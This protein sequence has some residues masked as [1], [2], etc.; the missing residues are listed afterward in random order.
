F[1]IAELFH[2]RLPK[3]DSARKYLERVV[4]DTATAEDSIY[5]RRAL[6]ALAWMETEGFTEKDGRRSVTN[7][8]RGQE[9]YRAVLARYPATEWAKAAERN[10]GLPSTVR[11][12]HDSARTL[13]L[14]AERRRFAGEPFARVRQAYQDVVTR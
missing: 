1:M 5:T 6:Y 11:T 9:L 12:P 2:F 7:P 14:E 8:A 13:L 3:A 10:L 4:A